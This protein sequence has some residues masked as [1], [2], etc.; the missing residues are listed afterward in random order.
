VSGGIQPNVGAEKHAAP[1]TGPSRAK[2]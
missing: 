2:P 1:R